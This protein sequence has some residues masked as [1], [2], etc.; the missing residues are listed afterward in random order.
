[1]TIEGDE[2]NIGNYELFCGGLKG[3]V[4]GLISRGADGLFR[5]VGVGWAP[6]RT[7]GTFSA[8]LTRE[9]LSVASE[10]TRLFQVLKR[11]CDRSRKTNYQTRSAIQDQEGSSY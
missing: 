5:S 2:S 10:M 11:S 9:N 6:S 4:R 8:P 7:C 3:L 1:M